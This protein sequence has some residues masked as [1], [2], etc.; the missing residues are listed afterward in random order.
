VADEEGGKSGIGSQINLIA[1]DY[2]E[3]DERDCLEAASLV[4]AA[5]QAASGLS[6]PFALV[7]AVPWRSVQRS[8]GPK[9]SQATKSPHRESLSLAEGG[10]K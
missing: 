7:E 2:G 4:E 3:L 8:I 9:Q 6:F 5:K 10:E 1:I